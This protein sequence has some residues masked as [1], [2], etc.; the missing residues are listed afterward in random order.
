MPARHSRGELGEAGCFYIK[1]SKIIAKK[2]LIS[3]LVI[4]IIYIGHKQLGGGK[5]KINEY[6]NLLPSSLVYFE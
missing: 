1:N 5:M 6:L 4:P 3:I 2:N